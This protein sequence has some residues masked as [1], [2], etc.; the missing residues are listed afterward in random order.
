MS[1]ADLCQINDL[2]SF[3]GKTQKIHHFRGL[4]FVSDDEEDVIFCVANGGYR[5][6]LNV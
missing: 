2:L 6:L 3:S 1:D 4:R 5:Y